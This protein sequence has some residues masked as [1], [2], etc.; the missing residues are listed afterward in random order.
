MARKLR[1][2]ADNDVYH[3]I[4]RRV[5]RLELFEDGGDYQAFI[6]VLDEVAP[7]FPIRILAYCLMPN[8][9][10]FL[11]WPRKG[12]ALPGFMQRLTVTHMRRWHAHR[13]STGEGPVYQGRY[14]SFPVQDDGNLLT[15]ARYIERNA[16]RAKLVSRAEQWRWCSLFDRVNKSAPAWLERPSAWPVTMRSD[17]VSWVNRAETAKELE[18]LRTSVN[19]GRPYGSAV[20]QIKTAGRLG[21]NQ[22]LRD[23]WRPKNDEQPTMTEGRRK[24]GT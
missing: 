21:L 4:N 19:R 12:K 10:H 20:W 8:H 18:A 3:V 14:K 22:T 9:W 1:V 24:K 5:A 16:L 6:K 13:N 11:L 2:L 23:P 17:W 7:L 15:V